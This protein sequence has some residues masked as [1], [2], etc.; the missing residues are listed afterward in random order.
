MAYWNLCTKK[1]YEQNG[2]KKV[3][4]LNVGTMRENSEGKRFIELNLLPGT[5]IY[6]FEPKARDTQEKWDE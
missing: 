4:W 1:E 2:E 3:K 5:T 6:C